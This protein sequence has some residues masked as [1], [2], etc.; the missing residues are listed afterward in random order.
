[1]TN[2]KNKLF[3]FIIS[4]IPGAGEMYL[5]FYKMGASIMLLFW[6][7]V[8]FFGSLFPPVVYFLPIPWFFSFFHTH[9][10]NNLPDDEFYALEDDYLFHLQP[11]DLK[12][13]VTHYQKPLAAIMILMGL[14]V[15]W[16]Y[17]YGGFQKL[18]A[19]L[20]ISSV[21]FSLI[22]Y[23]IMAI[24]QLAAAVFF[25]WLGCRLFRQKKVSLREPERLE[26]NEKESAAD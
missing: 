13:L 25:I 5:G 24:P 17:L 1:M 23:W 3:T 12:F 7:T 14:C 16:R 10:L 11:G 18:L 19:L 9:N 6:G 21:W 8:V 15:I 4:L 2:K 26:V 22:H 20:G